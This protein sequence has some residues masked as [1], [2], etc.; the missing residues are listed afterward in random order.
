MRNENILKRADFQF[1]DVRASRPVLVTHAF[2]VG[3]VFG[4]DNDIIEVGVGLERITDNIL[5][6]LGAS[7]NTL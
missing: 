7:L 5:S 6:P 2:E 3:A 4:V 1:V